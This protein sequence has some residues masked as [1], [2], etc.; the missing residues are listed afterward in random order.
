MS[1]KKSNSF[2]RKNPM[3]TVFCSI[4][5]LTQSNSGKLKFLKN[6][7]FPTLRTHNFLIKVD[8]SLKIFFSKFQLLKINLSKTSAIYISE[9]FESGLKGLIYWI[10]LSFKRGIVYFQ[11]YE[12][13]AI[14]NLKLV[15]FSSKVYPE[16]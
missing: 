5:A 4:I 11:N 12:C 9:T 10:E 8:E 15:Y 16:T 3:Q 7:N 13:G 2:F 14:V 6:L 1:I